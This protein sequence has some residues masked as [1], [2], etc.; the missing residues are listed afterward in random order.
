MSKSRRF[1]GERTVSPLQGISFKRIDLI[2]LEAL[3]LST[4][5]LTKD[6]LH[7]LVAVRATVHVVLFSHNKSLEQKFLQGKL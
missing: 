1:D 5:G 3:E 6:S 2:A 4:I 7:A